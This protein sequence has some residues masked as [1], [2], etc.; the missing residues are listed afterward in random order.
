MS[1]SISSRLRCPLYN[2]PP[3]LKRSCCL[4]SSISASAQYLFYIDN[5]TEN[6][7]FHPFHRQSQSRDRGNCLGGHA[8]PVIQPENC[9]FLLLL[10]PVPTQP[11]YF[12]D[13]VEEDLIFR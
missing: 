7:A 13:L 3:L 11:Q 2:Y 5:Q 6:A 12:I 10:W 9:P 1:S 8:V 4:N